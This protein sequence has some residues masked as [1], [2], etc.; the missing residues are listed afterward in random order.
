MED[1]TSSSVSP[2]SIH[3]ISARGD[4]NALDALVSINPD[5]IHEKDKNGWQ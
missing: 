5:V 2:L 3:Q 1:T 4:L